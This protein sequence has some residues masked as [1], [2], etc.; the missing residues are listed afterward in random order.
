[1]A[2][3]G[4]A[5]LKAEEERLEKE[6]EIQKLPAAQRE[7]LLLA[8]EVYEKRDRT[9]GPTHEDTL[10]ARN[11]LGLVLVRLDRLEEA[12]SLLKEGF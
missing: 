2:E 9:L 11:H 1:D 7:A 12:E 6:G 5:A 8:T 3:R 10:A 4:K